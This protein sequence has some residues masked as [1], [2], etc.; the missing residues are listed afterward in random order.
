VSTPE[1][2]AWAQDE[3]QKRKTRLRDLQLELPRAEELTGGAVL[4]RR[5]R[6]LLD[7]VRE[8]VAPGP[9][10]TGETALLLLG[11]LRELLH[12]FD[13]P[14]RIATECQVLRDRIREI[15]SRLPKPG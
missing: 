2:P 4:E 15:E 14:G 7:R 13:E 9:G 8:L 6:R 5:T 11:Q 3:L 1:A 10:Q 12:A